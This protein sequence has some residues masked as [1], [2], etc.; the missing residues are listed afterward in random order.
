MPDASVKR[1]ETCVLP[2]EKLSPGTLEACVETC[3]ISVAVGAVQNTEV[4][5]LLDDETIILLGHPVITGGVEST[6]RIK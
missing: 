6:A 3:E 2:I 4:P 5:W 1:Y